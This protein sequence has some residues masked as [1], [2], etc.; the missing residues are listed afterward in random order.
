MSLETGSRQHRSHVREIEPGVLA[1]FPSPLARHGYLLPDAAS[2]QR[3]HAYLARFES[4][5]LFAAAAILL[6]AWVL[7][8]LLLDAPLLPAS[9][10]IVAIW[11][12]VGLL[13]ARQ[14]TLRRV[15]TGLT[16][17]TDVRP[18]WAR[19]VALHTATAADVVRLVLSVIVLCTGIVLL[20]ST[21]ID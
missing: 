2:E 4:P 5:L 18:V 17:V 12:V 8:R 20:V 6:A 13:G 9:G 1:F 19:F 11:L 7:A 10:A 15:T 14:Y 21:F 3:V 16:R